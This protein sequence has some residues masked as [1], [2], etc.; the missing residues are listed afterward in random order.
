MFIK[1]QPWKLTAC[2]CTSTCHIRRWLASSGNLQLWFHWGRSLCCYLSPCIHLLDQSISLLD[3]L[4]LFPQSELQSGCL[5]ERDR[6]RLIQLILFTS[7]PI[8]MAFRW[9]CKFDVFETGAKIE[10][11]DCCLH[12]KGCK[13]LHQA[14][15]GILDAQGLL[16]NWDRKF[17][18]EH[19]FLVNMFTKNQ[20]NLCV[21]TWIN[22]CVA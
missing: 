12:L 2:A 6:S 7:S 21:L 8:F 10:S 16:A 3:A 14:D 17:L 18:N 4:F 13:R 11:R 9:T 20:F 19:S 5:L 22:W 1:F 15:G